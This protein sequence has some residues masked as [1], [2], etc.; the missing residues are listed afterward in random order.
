MRGSRGWSAAAVRPQCGMPYGKGSHQP[1]PGSA[2][3]PPL[4]PVPPAVLA[5]RRSHAA[6]VLPAPLTLGRL[7]AA[8]R[9]LPYPLPHTPA[10]AGP[11]SHALPH[12]CAPCSPA[13]PLPTHPTPAVVNLC[14]ADH[15]QADLPAV[16][17][18]KVAVPTAPQAAAGERRPG[19]AARDPTYHLPW[20]LAFMSFVP[21]D[22]FS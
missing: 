10:R 5:V 12:V 2:A 11:Q 19:P 21:D 22:C 7:V 14:P 8:V 13:T 4:Q 3:A 9:Q 6:C 16:W 20:L 15:L 17:P 1:S 18:A